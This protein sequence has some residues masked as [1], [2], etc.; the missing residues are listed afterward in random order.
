MKYL[1]LF[2][3]VLVLAIFIHSIFFGRHD[4]YQPSRGEQL[5]N[6]TLG[7]A[8]KKIHEKYK[9]KPSGAGAAMP[10]GPIRDL[11][12][13]F[14][15]NNRYSRHELRE[16]LIAAS[17][18]LLNEVSENEEIQA[19]L[20]NPPF[21]I[22]NIDIII[23]NHNKHGEGLRDPEISVARISD[24]VLVYKTVDPEDRFNYKSRFRETYAEAIRILERGPT[25]E[26]TCRGRQRAENEG[27]ERQPL[28]TIALERKHFRILDLFPGFLCPLAIEPCIPEDFVALTR[29]VP[30]FYDW[31][32][33]GPRKVLEAYFRDND[34]LEVPILRLKISPTVAQTGPSSFNGEDGAEF[35]NH[36]R[37]ASPAGL[38]FSERH[39]GDYPVFAIT[40]EREGCVKFLAFVGLNDPEG[41]GTL[42]FELVYPDRAGHPNEKDREFWENFLAKTTPLEGDDYSALLDQWPCF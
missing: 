17:R 32:Y 37:A 9:L 30:D 42:I 1:L 36:W 13:A 38:V 34:S 6:L 31:V 5:V 33:W 10:G 21:T 25:A 11:T 23:F 35:A 22:E 41:E 18:E 26:T 24:G 12:L 8:A 40:T 14:D 20:V 27:S 28:G 3:A 7:R 19:F 39:W 29:G 15:T 2:I 4:T 16:L